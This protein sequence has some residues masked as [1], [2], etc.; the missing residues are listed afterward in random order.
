MEEMASLES[1][2]A[3]SLLLSGAP[4]YAHIAEP[5]TDTRIEQNT[6]LKAGLGGFWQAL[7]LARAALRPPRPSAAQNSWRNLRGDAKA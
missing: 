5:L 4:A 1:L 3:L 2:S 7:R 6:A